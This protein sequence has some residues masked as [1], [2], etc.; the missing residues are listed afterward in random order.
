MQRKLLKKYC[1]YVRNK[2]LFYQILN[3]HTTSSNFNGNFITLFLEHP[4]NSAKFC[5]FQYFFKPPSL[6]KVFNLIFA[7]PFASILLSL[8]SLEQCFSTFFSIR[9]P[10]DEQNVRGTFFNKE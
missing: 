10:F 1:T 6:E 3:H 4:S 7:F 8:E 9:N 5:T 2:Y